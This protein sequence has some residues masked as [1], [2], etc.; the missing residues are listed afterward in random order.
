MHSRKRVMLAL[1]GGAVLFAASANAAATRL[2]ISERSFKVVWTP[3]TAG[4][5]PN[6]GEGGGEVL[7][8]CNVTMEGSFHSS[9]IAKVAGSL[10]GSVTGATVD[11]RSCSERGGL[12]GSFSFLSGTLPWHIAYKSFSGTLPLIESVRVSFLGMGL[13]I[14]ASLLNCLTRSTAANP[15]GWVLTREVRG[16]ITGFAADAGIIL[17]ALTGLGCERWHGVYMGNGRLTR[18][19]GATLLTLTLI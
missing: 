12:G 9:T 3:M 14:T 19:E 11:A 16:P 13:G 4:L 17:P 7:I 10:V 18:P 15:A 6:M 1:L 5:V 2:S 8:S